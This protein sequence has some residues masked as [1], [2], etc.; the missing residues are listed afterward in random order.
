MRVRAFNHSG[1]RQGNGFVITDF[2]SQIAEL[3]N[4]RRKK[5]I[6]VGDLSARRDISDVRDIV[7]GYRLALEKGRPGEVYLLCRGQAVRIETVLKKLLRHST[8]SIDIVVDKNL[9]R[10]TEVPVLRGDASKA[11]KKLGYKR[12]YSLDD[13]LKDCLE[14]YRSLQGGKSGRSSKKDKR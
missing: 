2:A 1:P 8:V 14:Y 6:K 10:S 7:R 4:S 13:T 5:I 9:I 3:E 11:E 12:N